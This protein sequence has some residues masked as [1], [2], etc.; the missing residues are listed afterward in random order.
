MKFLEMKERKKWIWEN[1]SFKV[2]K[3]GYVCEYITV[4]VT[5]I[6]WLSDHKTAKIDGIT[7]EIIK[8]LDENSKQPSTTLTNVEISFMV[9]AAI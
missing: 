4:E 6:Q 9:T 2:E 8:L 1:L 7:I 3:S 5:F